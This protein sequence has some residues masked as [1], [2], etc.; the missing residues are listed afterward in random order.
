MP[1]FTYS[2][3]KMTPEEMASDEMK[4]LREKFVKESINDA[5][6]VI[7]FVEPTCPSSYLYIYLMFISTGN[8]SRYENRYAQVWQ[9]QE[10]ELYLQSIANKIR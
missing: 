9:M 8:R 3:A 5:Q 1:K 7:N 10:E 2:L 6:L 4:K